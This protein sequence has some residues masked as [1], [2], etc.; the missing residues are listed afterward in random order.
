[1]KASDMKK[2]FTLIELLIVISIIAILASMLL[3]ALST[4]KA[5]TRAMKC[6]SNQKQ[7]GLALNMYSN[8]FNDYTCPKLTYDNSYAW[9]KILIDNDYVTKCLPEKIFSNSIL[10]CPDGKGS[11]HKEDRY[12]GTSFGLNG[13]VSSSFTVPRWFKRIQITHP[14]TVIQ[15]MDSITYWVRFYEPTF[16]LFRHLGKTNILFFDG[17]VNSKDRNLIP[18]GS[19]A[20]IPNEVFY[21]WWGPERSGW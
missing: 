18:I 7:V 1:M 13:C 11:S 16:I 4:V 6:S 12:Y 19:I 5:K 15:A 8:D 10:M 3:P 17:H 21:E 14:S 2:E 20:S 9:S